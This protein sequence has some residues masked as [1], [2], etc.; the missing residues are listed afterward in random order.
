MSRELGA[1][2]DAA[3]LR[4]DTTHRKE[5]SRYVRSLTGP[6]RAVTALKL[7]IENFAEQREPADARILLEA[8]IAAKQPAAAEP[9]LQWMAK[10]GIDSMAL[11][12]LTAQLA[13]M[14][15]VKS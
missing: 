3:R 15:G 6:S 4:G 12:K 5:E 7:A 13:S 2:F 8:A 10:S 1:R 14:S 11:K 9:A